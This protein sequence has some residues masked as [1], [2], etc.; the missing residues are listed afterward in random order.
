M[1][2]VYIVYSTWV[3]YDGWSK[4][5]DH[6]HRAFLDKEKAKQYMFDETGVESALKYGH[7]DGGSNKGHRWSINEVDLDD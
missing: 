6:I 3:D 5:G 2:K 1:N 4:S 7:V